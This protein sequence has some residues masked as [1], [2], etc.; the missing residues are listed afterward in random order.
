[1]RALDGV[2]TRS[3]AVSGVDLLH[4]S[5]A[6]DLRMG[7]VQGVYSWGSA[8]GDGDLMRRCFRVDCG[9]FSWGGGGGKEKASGH[10]QQGRFSLDDVRFLTDPFFLCYILYIEQWRCRCKHDS[11]HCG[12]CPRS[13][14]SWAD[15][16]D[17][18]VSTTFI[19]PLPRTEDGGAATPRS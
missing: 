16:C 17:V 7:T 8:L 18:Q 6:M 19:L 9:C 10:V 11:S 4:R 15:T 13:S 5:N 12:R 2:S 3:L 1:M 14:M